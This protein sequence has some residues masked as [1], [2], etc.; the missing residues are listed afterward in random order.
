MGSTVKRV[1]DLRIGFQRTPDAFVPPMVTLFRPV[2]KEW[3]VAL[4]PPPQIKP[5]KERD[6]AS[7]HS[8]FNET[9]VSWQDLA[10]ITVF[11]CRIRSGKRRFA[12]L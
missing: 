9:K 4:P 1:R 12:S 3:D 6:E 7:E 2:K 10:G 11:N 5:Q 8:L